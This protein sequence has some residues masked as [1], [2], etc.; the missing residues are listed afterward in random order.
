MPWAAAA[1][2]AEVVRDGVRGVG[3]AVKATRRTEDENISPSVLRR[4]VM[5][6]VDVEALDCAIHSS[7]GRL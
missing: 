4:G 7:R 3:G 6:V 1:R 2:G 5:V